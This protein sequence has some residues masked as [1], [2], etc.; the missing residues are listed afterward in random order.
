[1]RQI[2]V[3]AAILVALILFS[4]LCPPVGEALDWAKTTLTYSG[5]LAVLAVILAITARILFGRLGR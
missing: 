4:F 5:A 2:L 1:M 3:L